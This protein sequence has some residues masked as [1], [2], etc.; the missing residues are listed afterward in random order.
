M[1]AQEFRLARSGWIALPVLLVAIHASADD[2]VLT[3]KA[4]IREGFVQVQSFKVPDECQDRGKAVR[5]KKRKNEKTLKLPDGEEVAISVVYNFQAGNEYISGNWV[6]DTLI[7]QAVLKFDASSGAEYFLSV[8]VDEDT[9]YYDLVDEDS[10]PVPYR[11]YALIT[12]AE[13][14]S[15]VKTCAGN[16][17]ILDKPA[18][19]HDTLPGE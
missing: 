17:E 15:I 4:D 16:V 19:L 5:L 14:M 12:E 8:R 7:G 3:V 6:S 1:A 18:A 10:T 9:M 13:G 11:T 2:A